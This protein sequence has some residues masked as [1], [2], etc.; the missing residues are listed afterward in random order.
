M[1]PCKLAQSV[2]KAV[3]AIVI[4]IGEIFHSP[5]LLSRRR[6]VEVLPAS[7]ILFYVQDVQDVEYSTILLY[8]FP[9]G[10]SKPA[11]KR[12]RGGL[13]TGGGNK[14]L[15]LTEATLYLCTGCPCSVRIR[16]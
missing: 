9:P 6:A 11:S 5:L 3:V 2:F 1:C 7:S 12:G 14:R 8:L 16:A 13:G 4:H 15:Y 10:E